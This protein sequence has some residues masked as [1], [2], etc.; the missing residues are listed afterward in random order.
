MS[1]KI[2]HIA[3]L[4][5]LAAFGVWLISRPVA[6]TPESLARQEA[7]QQA[8]APGRPDGSGAVAGSDDPDIVRGLP[9]VP[10][11]VDLQDVP[12]APAEEDELYQRY[13]NGEIDLEVNEGPVSE[14]ILAALKQESA[15]QH[16]DRTV[17]NYTGDELLSTLTMGTNFKSLDYTQSQQGVPPDADIMVGQD[18][19]VVGVNTSFQV[20]NKAGNSL[21]APTLYETFWGNQCGTGSATMHYFDPFSVYDEAAG[22]YVMGI[23]AYDTAVNGGDNGYACIAVSKT[24][25]ATGQWWTYSFDGNPGAGTDYFFDYPHIGVGQNALYLGA[26]MFGA[27]YVRSHIFALDKNAMYNG[28]VANHVKFNSTAADFTFQPVK[29]SGYTTG[30]WPTNPNEPHYFITANYGNNQ[31]VLKVWKFADPWGTASFTQAGSITVNG[32][33]LPIDQ[34]QAGNSGL[35]QGNDNRLLDAHYRAGRLWT[36]HTIGCNPGS[37]TVNCVRWYEINIS[38]GTPVL[39]QQGT[40]AS[41][42]VYRSFPNLAVNRCGDMVVGYSHFSSSTY[43]ST[44]AAGREAGDAPGTLKNETL[45]HAGEDYYTSF[46]PSPRRWG[47]YTGMVIDPDGLRFWYV[48]QYSRNQA[49]ARWS[50]WVAA[51]TF[52]GCSGGGPQNE[53]V[54]LP[55]II[56]QPASAPPPP[57]ATPTSQ[58]P[59]GLVNGGFE[60]GPDAGWT[61]YSSLGYELIYHSNDLPVSAHGGAWA[62]WM[63]G[64]LNEVANLRQQVTVPPAQP[65]LSYWHWIDSD[66][67]CGFDFAGV[68]VNG[69]TAEVYSLCTDNNTNGWVKRVVNLSAYAGQSIDLRIQSETDDLYNSTMFVDDVA[70]QAS[71]AGAGEMVPATGSGQTAITKAAAGLA[72]VS[73]PAADNPTRLTRQ[74]L[75]RP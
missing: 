27:A 64:V 56:R 31:T 37:G 73:P 38:S 57:T 17:Q 52:P 63:G 18:H 48:G 30:S 7:A 12:S 70:F 55:I 60:A 22:R 59:A 47:D 46:D 44:Y 21:V 8:F 25:S 74:Y 16:V 13:L 45:I 10:G 9:V 49:V 15:E 3:L 66:D 67:E 42:G 6:L 53:K 51:F 72:P 71:A 35:M 14:A 50:T 40:F 68:I 43:P 2:K 65:Y 36:T 19:I 4:F 28:Q 23:T 39:V 75:T 69:T 32:Y 62:A 5:V 1:S 58:P 20:F 29:L 26:N 61:Q 54:N 41:N 24:N 33:S 11:E 34:P